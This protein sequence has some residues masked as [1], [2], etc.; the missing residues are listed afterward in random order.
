[1]HHSITQ[2]L[3]EMFP[4]EE[5]GD[6]FHAY[7]YLKHLNHFMYHA[8][9]ASGST[10]KE[11]ESDLGDDV[12]DLLEAMVQGVGEA[13]AS[14]DTSTYHGKVVQLREALQLVS[15]K[16]NISLE[17]PE[18][19]IPYQQARRIILENPDSISVGEC[20]CR[21]AAET[22]CLGEGEL[23]VCL[24]VGDPHAAFLREFNPKFRK[25]SQDKAV[26][27]LEDAHARGF[28]HCAYFK[29]DL[30]RR[31]F[32][33]CNCCS[34]CCQGMKAWNVF[35]GAIP[36][37]APSG[38][39]SEI[40]D[41]CN[42]CGVCVDACGFDAISV[43]EDTQ[44]HVVDKDKCMGCGVC[45]DVC[46]VE[47]INLRREPSKGDPLDLEELLEATPAP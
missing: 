11:P 30:G 38:Y 45:E 9:K 14:R 39:L 12:N 29:K 3:Y 33:I 13:A 5:K 19:V 18:T 32:A 8:L 40:S 24:F 27:L 25:I 31:F 2:A 15:Q 44:N 10:P 34:C 7:L 20:A 46:V 43:D 36:I 6:F 35:G 1:M 4:R 17:P 22:S 37:L 28:V 26:E 41:E 47:A 16:R 42:D 21:A 23:D